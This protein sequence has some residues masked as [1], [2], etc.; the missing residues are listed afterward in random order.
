MSTFYMVRNKT[1]RAFLNKKGAW[2]HGSYRL[3]EFDSLEA[4]QA[5][6]PEG[7][8]CEVLT[9]HRKEET[10]APDVTAYQFFLEYGNYFLNKTD[11]FKAPTFRD[12]SVQVFDTEASA[13]DKAEALELDL[14][15]IRVLQT[16]KRDG[17]TP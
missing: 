9:K 13:L 8:D 14:D 16:K 11:A 2:S 1:T 15:R 4:A 6:T 7:A 17:T 5:A 12:A 3:A 10:G